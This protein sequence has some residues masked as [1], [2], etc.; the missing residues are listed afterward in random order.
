MGVRQT[1]RARQ[2][3][4]PLQ[5]HRLSCVGSVSGK[6]VRS[7]LFCALTR[8]PTPL[9]KSKKNNIYLYLYY[10]LSISISLLYPSYYIPL[11]FIFCIDVFYLLLILNISII[12][13]IR[14]RFIFDPCISF[15][16]QTYSCFTSAM[17][18]S[19]FQALLP[20]SPWGFGVLRYVI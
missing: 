9:G 11:S 10:S 16:Y 1:R 18:K 2:A 12:I 6:V 17:P 8:P 5:A 15:M 7:V 14:I 13:L 3:R 20:R 19:T 4:H